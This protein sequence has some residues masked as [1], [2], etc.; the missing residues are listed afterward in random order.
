M[1]KSELEHI[2]EELIT[3]YQ[4]LKAEV[5]IAEL[6]KNSNLTN[7]DVVVHHKS[8]FKRSHRRDILDIGLIEDNKL[9]VNLSRNGLYDQLPEGLFHTKDTKNTSITYTELRKTYKKEEQDARHFFLP[10]EN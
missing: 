10:L 2:F 8:A 4:N 7:K 6:Q 3:V 5:I 1:Q 9:H